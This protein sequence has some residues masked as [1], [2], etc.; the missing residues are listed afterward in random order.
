MSYDENEFDYSILIIIGIAI[1][2]VA[3]GVIWNRLRFSKK[4]ILSFTKLKLKSF[5]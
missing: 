2:G 4:Y 1:I 5:P 3:L